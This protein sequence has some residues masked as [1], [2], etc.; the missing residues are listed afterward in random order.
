VAEHAA[1]DSTERDLAAVTR[2]LDD[3]LREVAQLSDALGR[4]T[5]PV[6]VKSVMLRLNQAGEQFTRLEKEQNALL[7]QQQDR[8]AFVEGLTSLQ[9]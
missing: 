5:N 4:I 3:A 9:V 1:S 2:A 6:A 8:D 7:R